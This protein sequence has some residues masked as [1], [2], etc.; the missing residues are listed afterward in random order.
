MDLAYWRDVALVV[1][2]VEALIFGIIPL[3]L[4]ALA[5]RGVR[6]LDDK[7][8]T[9]GTQA[10]DAWSDMDRRVTRAA[11]AIRAPFERAEEVAALLKWL[12]PTHE[13]GR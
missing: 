6:W 3:I 9:Y 5:I 7:A 10:R 2:S 13:D 4:F 8:R 12:I 11:R 1:L